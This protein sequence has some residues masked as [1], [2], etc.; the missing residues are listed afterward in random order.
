VFVGV[1]CQFTIMPLVGFGLTRVLSFP[2]EIAAGV[3]LI[4]AC[5]S[6]LASNVMAYL[7][8]ANLALSITMTS[9][10]TMIAPLM[11]PFWMKVLAGDRVQISFVGMMSDILKLVIAPIGAA[12]VHDYLKHASPAARRILLATAAAGAGWLAYQALVGWSPT[13]GPSS[14]PAGAWMTICNYLLGAIAFG[15]LFHALVKVVPSIER[16][17]PLAS[18]FGI[19]YFTAVTTAKGRTELLAVGGLLFLAAA[20]HNALGYVLG[21][22]MSRALGVTRNSARTVTFEVGLQNG[23]MASGIAAQLDMLG[24]MGL[25]AAVFSPWMNITGSILANYWRKRPADEADQPT[26]SLASPRSGEAKPL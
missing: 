26:E 5:S 11:T 16:R 22:W 20:I 14:A 1:L 24:T 15:V 18:M 2:D 6:G 7:A 12:L 25:A 3:I 17:M 13:P 9:V 4:G 23:G 21:Y 10:T 19:I 8:R